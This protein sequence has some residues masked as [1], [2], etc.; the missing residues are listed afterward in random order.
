MIDVRKP[1]GEEDQQLCPKIYKGVVL[2][3]N[4]SLP[5]NGTEGEERGGVPVRAVGAGETWNMEGERLDP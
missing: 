2:K 3:E 5:G 4:R 1:A